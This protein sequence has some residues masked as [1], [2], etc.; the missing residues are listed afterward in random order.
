MDLP[1]V[2]L[3]DLLRVVFRLYDC[4]FPFEDNLVPELP[5]GFS[6]GQFLPPLGG[7]GGTGGGGVKFSLDLYSNT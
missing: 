5:A 2:T 3:G 1:L 4:S 7:G 6:T